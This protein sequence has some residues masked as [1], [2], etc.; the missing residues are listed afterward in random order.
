MWKITRSSFTWYICIE[1]FLYSVVLSKDITSSY[2]TISVFEWYARMV[3]CLPLWQGRSRSSPD[4]STRLVCDDC[5]TYICAC[6]TLLHTSTAV[7]DSHHFSHMREKCF[8]WK[9]VTIRIASLILFSVIFRSRFYPRVRNS[10][11][12]IVCYYLP[13]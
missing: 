9:R 7:I 3:Q 2:N 10:I 12:W 8:S 4:R 11:S 5:L 6:G 13:D 1:Q